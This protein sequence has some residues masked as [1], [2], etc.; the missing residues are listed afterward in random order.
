MKSCSYRS[1]SQFDMREPSTSPTSI[2]LVAM[3]ARPSL[4]SAREEATKRAIMHY[5]RRGSGPT[6]AMSVQVSRKPAD[7]SFVAAAG[8]GDADEVRRLL[9]HG[10]SVDVRTRGTVGGRTC[11]T[12]WVVR[13]W[14]KTSGISAR[15]SCGPGKRRSAGNKRGRR[16]VVRFDHPIFDHRAVKR[17]EQLPFGGG[18]GSNDLVVL[19]GA[20]TSLRSHG[21]RCRRRRSLDRLHLGSARLFLGGGA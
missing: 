9:P 3:T 1:V 21:G 6:T 20:R 8:K 18:L 2:A 14:R 19:G 13:A 7:L 17:Y 11:F 16:K 12:I 15:S 5:H 10:T 4:P